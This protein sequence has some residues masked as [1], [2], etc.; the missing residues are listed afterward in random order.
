MAKGL[1]EIINKQIMTHGRK[2]LQHLSILM[3]WDK[4]THAAL[5]ASL[6]GRA[7]CGALLWWLKSSRLRT[8]CQGCLGW[9][10]AARTLC[11]CHAGMNKV[12]SGPS[13][14]VLASDYE[15]I[16][17]LPS[18]LYVTSYGRALLLYTPFVPKL[19]NWI[20]PPPPPPLPPL[21]LVQADRPAD[22]LIK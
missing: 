14:S 3:Q 10:W 9:T 17:Q 21:P 7:D 12:E 1:A 11:H 16:T 20:S 8:L 5:M 6:W 18:M 4:H 15:Q 19:N 22:G 13:I 2:R